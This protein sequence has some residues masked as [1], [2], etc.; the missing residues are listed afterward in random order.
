[1]NA[2]KSTALSA[3][4]ILRPLGAQ[5]I[6]GTKIA[7]AADRHLTDENGFDDLLHVEGLSQRREM[8]RLADHIA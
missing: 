2:G 3:D 1:M 4:Q 8:M 6:P 7:M 5:R